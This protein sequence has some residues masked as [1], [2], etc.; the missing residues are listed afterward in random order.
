MI[1]TCGTVITMVNTD[2]DP[3]RR[4][5]HASDGDSLGTVAV[6]SDTV[7]SFHITVL[8]YFTGSRLSRQEHL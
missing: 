8:E 4:R 7:V 1:Q 5:S 2:I 6:G 3:S